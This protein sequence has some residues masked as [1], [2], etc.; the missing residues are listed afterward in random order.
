M[1]ENLQKEKIFPKF[2]LLEIDVEKP[3]KEI[4]GDYSTNIALRIAEIIIKKE[5]MEIV[6]LL[7]SKLKITGSQ[8]FERI[9]AARPGFINFF[10]F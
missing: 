1:I 9:K 10:S 2:N 5:S 3:K 4:H 8:F 6:E 7:I